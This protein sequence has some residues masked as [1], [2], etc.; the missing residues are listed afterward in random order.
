MTIRGT[1]TWTSLPSMEQYRLDI[2][3][4]LYGALERV[5]SEQIPVW[6]N[7]LYRMS[8]CGWLT[9]GRFNSRRYLLCNFC[10]S[11]AEAVEAAIKL[12]R[13]ATGKRTIISTYKAFT[14]KL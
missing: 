7:R 2:I 8:L 6:F 14:G 3:R 1:N 12:A 10:Q 5:K 9:F 4:I 11:G 13:S